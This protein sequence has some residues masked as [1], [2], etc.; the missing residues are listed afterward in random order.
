[1]LCFDKLNGEHSNKNTLKIFHFVEYIFKFDSKQ[2]TNKLR[3]MEYKNSDSQ[4]VENGLQKRHL[5]MT[6]QTTCS[7]YMQNYNTIII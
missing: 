6:T 5:Y 1:M 3:Y 2:Y 4:T 7:Y